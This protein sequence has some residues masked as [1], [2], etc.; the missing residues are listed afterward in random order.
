MLRGCLEEFDGD[1]RLA[2]I[3]VVDDMSTDRTAALARAVAA[4]DERVRLLSNTSQMGC[5]PSVLRGFDAAQGNFLFF[6]PADGQILPDVARAC[7]D[8]AA[9]AGADVVM[10]RRVDRQ[11]PWYRVYLSRVYNLAI[12]A[13]LR[14][15]PAHDIDSSC[16]FRRE[17]IAGHRPPSEATTFTLV[18]LV[19]LAR[20]RHAKIVEIEIAHH[21][22]AGGISRGMRP[23]EMRRPASEGCL[24][25]LHWRFA[26]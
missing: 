26:R 10:T 21:P 2:E 5:V 17:L 11:D 18:E 16:L 4:D 15:F 13:I 25:I 22:R 12:R 3:V 20:E 24:S 14:G 9:E 6:L 8:A 23:R 7:L 19:L 1:P